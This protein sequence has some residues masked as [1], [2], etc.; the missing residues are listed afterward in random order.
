MGHVLA[1]LRHVRRDVLAGILK[2]D[3]ELH[4]RE[5]LVLE[6]LWQNADDTDELVFL[7]RSGDLPQARRFIE[8][9]HAEARRSNPDVNLPHMT[10]LIEES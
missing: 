10:F 3:A 7:F 5:G 9:V 1:R 4:T 6:H 2:A 8:K